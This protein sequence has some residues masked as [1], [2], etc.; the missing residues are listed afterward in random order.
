MLKKILCVG[1]IASSTVASAC[2]WLGTLNRGSTV[3]IGPTVSSIL[4]SNPAVATAIYNAAAAWNS[5]L[6]A[7]Y[8]EG[9]SGIVTGSDCPAYTGTMQIGALAFLG[10]TCPTLA[11]YQKSNVLALVDS[12]TRS[13]TVNLNFAWSLNPGLGEFDLQSVLTHEF[14]H[15]LGLGHQNNGECND[16]ST[17]SCSTSPRIETMNAGIAA[18][19]T[20]QR[21]LTN[22]D[23]DSANSLY[24]QWGGGGG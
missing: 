6:A 8:I 22:N 4:Q 23:V 19:T 21:V 17:Q 11:S 24:Y 5:T 20:C 16:N 12:S 2:P 15:M 3:S 1:L 13:I 14:G 9:Y 10:N 7:G 18:A